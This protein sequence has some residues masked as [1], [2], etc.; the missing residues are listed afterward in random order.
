LLNSRISLPPRRRQEAK[1]RMASRDVGAND[2]AKEINRIIMEWEK[3]EGDIFENA[4][5]SG[6]K[7]ARRKSQ[8]KDQ[9]QIK[10]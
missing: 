10:L 5:I 2:R 1:I 4:T 7:P 8:R 3:C 9:P 6:R